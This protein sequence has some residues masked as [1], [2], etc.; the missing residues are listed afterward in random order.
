MNK[1]RLLNLLLNERKKM[2]KQASLTLRGHQETKFLIIALLGVCIFAWAALENLPPTFLS[3]NL[4]MLAT[5]VPILGFLFF[6][7]RLDPLYGLMIVGIPLGI[8]FSI[9]ELVNMLQNA[10]DPKG[11]SLAV[12]TALSFAFSGGF[13]SAIGYFGCGKAEVIYA[14]KLKI[15][16]F[17]LVTIFLCIF[18]GGVMSGSSGLSPFIDIPS[19]KIFLAIVLIGIGIAKFKGLRV[20]ETL[21]HIFICVALIGA[22]F[23]TI[24]WM[25]TSLGSNRSGVGPAMAVGL[26]TMLYGVFFYVLSF[27]VC[28]TRDQL[29]Q[30]LNFGLKN[31]HL[32]EGFTFL[33]FMTLGPPTLFEVF[34]YDDLLEE[35]VEVDIGEIGQTETGVIIFLLIGEKHASGIVEQLSQEELVTFAATVGLTRNKGLGLPGREDGYLNSVFESVL[36]ATGVKNLETLVDKA[37]MTVDYGNFTPANTYQTLEN[38]LV[39][40]KDKE[41]HDS[42]IDNLSWEQRLAVLRIAVSEKPQ[43]IG[44]L[45]RRMIMGNRPEAIDVPNQNQ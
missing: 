2:E 7:I 45:I 12:S 40:L 22:A 27:L 8:V 36:G 29:P 24:G 44:G 10:S 1:I 4:W 5:I 39:T 23:S 43:E 31:W 33:F 30:D 35:Q 9:I 34:Y 32:V 16:D 20:L 18:Y 6:K 25:L 11:I 37:A 26:L 17:C 13:F 38:F 42:N 14:K 21:P 19:L 28:L 15:Q 41:F 3:V